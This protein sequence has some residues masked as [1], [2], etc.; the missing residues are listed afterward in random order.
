MSQ[1]S[2]SLANATI[3]AKAQ[4]DFWSSS[5]DP[6][7]SR[8]RNE[9]NSTVINNLEKSSGT[10]GLKP[11]SPE[12]DSNKDTEISQPRKVTPVNRSG[13][14]RSPGPALRP[15]K[16][17]KPSEQSAEL[18]IEVSSSPSPGTVSQLMPAIKPLEK[19]PLPFEERY[20]RTTTYLEMSLFH[21]VRDLHQC[22]EIAK[23]ASLFNAAVSE[24]L[25]RHY[26]NP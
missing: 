24:Y 12:E 17:A 1:R 18:V 5:Q 14:A 22:G 23:I 20:K 10:V 7:S 19:K 25:N 2:F 11:V 9:E 15:K 26:P 21:R 6:L 13:V 3:Q 8:E 16:L 4:R